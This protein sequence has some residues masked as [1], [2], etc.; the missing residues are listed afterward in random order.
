MVSSYKLRLAL[1]EQRRN[2]EQL[3][4]CSGLCCSRWS[5]TEKAYSAILV[6]RARDKQEQFVSRYP[7]LCREI[8][9]SRRRGDLHRRIEGVKT[10][11]NREIT[12]QIASYRQSA[13]GTFRDI[14]SQI[15]T[16]KQDMT[17]NIAN[18]SHQLA[19]K[20]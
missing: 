14:P 16:Y 12:S 19:G 20:R 1:S 8:K 11:A 4:G 18:L 5:K 3:V 7:G 17:R 15:T 9:L 13:D 10:S 6:R 2:Y